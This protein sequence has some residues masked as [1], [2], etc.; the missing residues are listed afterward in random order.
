MEVKNNILCFE[1]VYVNVNVLLIMLTKSNF[2]DAIFISLR[3]H[4]YF[5]N[6]FICFR[7]YELETALS[8][9]KKELEEIQ[10]QASQRESELLNEIAQKTKEIFELKE[11]IQWFLFMLTVISFCVLSYRIF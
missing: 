6:A 4:H 7:Q 2:N 8:M 3:L 10:T 1:N 11:I 5:P 9:A